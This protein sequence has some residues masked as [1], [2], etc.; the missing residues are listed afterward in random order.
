MLNKK[1]T[2]NKM[3]VPDFFLVFDWPEKVYEACI[4]KHSSNG[5]S[6]Q[7][8]IDKVTHLIEQASPYLISQFVC[9]I[10]DSTF[11]VHD[12][13]HENN[14]LD[15]LIK[16]LETGSANYE[17]W[18]PK[19][20]DIIVEAQCYG[21]PFTLAFDNSGVDNTTMLVDN[22]KFMDNIPL[23]LIPFTQIMLSKQIPPK[24][25]MWDDISH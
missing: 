3:A 19:S 2:I 12:R 21:G 23:T 9:D 20:A 15:F 24:F 13:P 22:G 11:T 6:R 14:Y 7:S 10:A 1:N 8:A 16:Y 5:K 25:M 4:A 18:F 17:F